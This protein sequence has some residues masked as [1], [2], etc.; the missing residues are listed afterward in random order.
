MFPA[1]AG[2]NRRRILPSTRLGYVSR[3]SGDEPQLGDANSPWVRVEVEMKSIQRIIPLDALLRPGE[4]LAAA[5]PAFG[6]ISEHQERILT[7][8]KKT[9][10]TYASMV[11]WV[12]CQCGAALNVLAEIEG[13]AEAALGKV[14][15]RGEIPARL[16][17]SSWLYTDQ[18]YVHEEPRIQ[19]HR[20]VFDAMAFA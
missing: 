1:S 17:A 8:Q 10:I 13:S 3:V 9:E 15:R 11:A 19:P 16:K 4:Y 18:E 20:E 5:Y 14:I 6:W 12:K 7:V 2:M